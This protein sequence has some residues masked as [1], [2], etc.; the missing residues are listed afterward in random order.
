MPAPARR[1]A[2]P[3]HILYSMYISIASFVSRQL[4]PQLH[5]YTLLL[6]AS[7]SSSPLHPRS[8]KTPQSRRKSLALP[9]EGRVSYSHLSAAA[10]YCELIPHSAMCRPPARHAL[11]RTRGAGRHPH[12][13]L[14]LHR[15]RRAGI[16]SYT[17]PV[18]AAQ[19]GAR[20]EEIAD[21]CRHN[22]SAGIK[23]SARWS[24]VVLGSLGHGQDVPCR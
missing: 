5:T 10:D 9:L 17:H 14:P 18:A 4:L 12:H 19:I 15:L 1:G 22:Q 23:A 11:V 6:H 7:S 2:A 3:T 13:H 8:R 24:C 21:N 20:A 16:L